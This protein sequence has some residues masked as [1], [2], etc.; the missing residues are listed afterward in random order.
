MAHYKNV[1]IIKYIYYFCIYSYSFSQIWVVLMMLVFLDLCCYLLHYVESGTLTVNG[2]R[3]KSFPSPH[4]VSVH[5][6]LIHSQPPA[7]INMA[8]CYCSLS[9]C[10]IIYIYSQVYFSSFCFRPITSTNLNVLNCAGSQKSYF[11]VWISTSIGD[12]SS[13]NQYSYSYIC[14]PLALANRY[15]M[16]LLEFMYCPKSYM[17][18]NVYCVHHQVRAE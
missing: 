1:I 15:W 3:N 16:L 6:A 13:S 11:L 18:G 12:Q 5:K 7:Y 10:F 14:P 4:N 17:F 8:I 2:Y 9:L